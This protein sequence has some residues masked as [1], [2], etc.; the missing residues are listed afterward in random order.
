VRWAGEGRAWALPLRHGSDSSRVRG[1][2]K[3]AL[4]V[5]L[6]MLVFAYPALIGHDPFRYHL[7][8]FSPA[9]AAL[10]LRTALLVFAYLFT[11]FAVWVRVGWIRLEQ[12]HDF[13]RLALRFVKGLWIPIPLALME[14]PLFRGVI[15]EE[16]CNAV[17]T[18]VALLA[19]AAAFA[20]AHFLRPQKHPAL[21]A[22]G[23][24]YVGLV[25]G[26]VYL[27]SGRNY[28]LPIAVHAAGVLFIQVTRPVSY[29]L[30]PSWLIGRSSYPVAGVLG[31][32]AVAAAVAII[33]LSL[34]P[35]GI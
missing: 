8:K 6:L 31:M 33:S 22:A 30:G 17:P 1:V 16:L 2:M 13:T 18:A 32:A 25:L 14:E 3:L 35:Q 5:G 4:G 19:S 15:L 21:A 23:L 34:W 9:H 24:F 11:L 29:Y 26:A 20:A 28:L 7:A 12:R 10:S 27:L